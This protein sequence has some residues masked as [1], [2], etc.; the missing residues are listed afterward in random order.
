MIDNRSKERAVNPYAQ[1]LIAH[2]SEGL[3]VAQVAYQHH[4]MRL[5]VTMSASN[6]SVDGQKESRCPWKD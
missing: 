1:S 2:L 3:M 5:D 4:R 6:E